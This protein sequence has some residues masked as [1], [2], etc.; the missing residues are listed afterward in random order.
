MKP[1]DAIRNYLVDRPEG[2]FSKTCTLEMESLLSSCWDHLAGSSDGGMTAE[3]LK[4]RTGSLEWSPPNLTFNIERHAEAVTGSTTAAVQRW[5]VDLELETAA[6][7]ES[8]SGQIIPMDRRIDVSSVAAELATAI[9]EQREDTRIEWVAMNRVRILTD[10]AIP[11]TMGMTTT[12]RRNRFVS[13]IERLL[14]PFGWLRTS[15]NPLSF[16]QQTSN[17]SKADQ[18][19]LNAAPA[20]PESLGSKVVELRHQ[21]RLPTPF[22]TSRGGFSVSPT[23]TSGN[24][25]TNVQMEC[26]PTTPCGR[27]TCEICTGPYRDRWIQRTLAIAESYPGVHHILNVTITGFPAT[28]LSS[29]NIMHFRAHLREHLKQA[30]FHGLLLRGG[31]DATWEA[32]N[33]WLVSARGLAIGVTPDAWRTIRANIRYNKYFGPKFQVKVR[34][35]QDP[36]REIPDLVKFHT[37]FWPRSRDGALPLLPPELVKQLTDWFAGETF[38]NFTFEFKQKR[39]D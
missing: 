12:S 4:G 16:E 19:S 32:Q 36:E 27:L 24:R 9:N 18:A 14:Q 20:F 8:G 23:S 11:A 6:L 39:R 13:E 10:E 33:Q 17:F 28:M 29:L 34:R 7:I 15:R 22:P 25:P 37:Y 3:K 2:W 38:K 30:G 26:T 31:I 1:L 35:L 5:E 21:R